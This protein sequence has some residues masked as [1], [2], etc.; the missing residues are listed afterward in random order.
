MNTIS[1]AG[2]T[3]VPALLALERAGFVIAAQLVAGNQLLS[4]TRHDEVF[5][6]DTPEALL[7][8][9]KLVELRGWQWQASDHEI[10]DTRSRYPWLG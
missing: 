10:E 2:N 8:L 5:H 3:L 7:G 1:T 6:A 4:A 9:I